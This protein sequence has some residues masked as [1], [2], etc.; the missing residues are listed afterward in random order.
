MKAALPCPGLVFLSTE[1][2]DARSVPKRTETGRLVPPHV[3][4]FC[5]RTRFNGR[6]FLER[7]AS[8]GL[9]HRWSRRGQP[10]GAKLHSAP[11]AR[12]TARLALMEI[13]VEPSGG[14]EQRGVAT[15]EA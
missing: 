9:Q 14:E 6:I 11:R 12:A 10:R 15:C 8:A 5:P 4:P 1:S 7:T 13:G 2:C 3:G